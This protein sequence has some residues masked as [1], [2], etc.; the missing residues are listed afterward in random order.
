MRRFAQYGGVRVNLL[1]TPEFVLDIRNSAK[2]LTTQIHIGREFNEE[3]L[4][5]RL[6]PDVPQWFG[7]TI[8]FWD[9]DALITWTSNVQ[10]W[11]SHGG[12]EFSNQ[13]QSIEIYTPRTGAEGEYIGLKHEAILYDDKAF[14]QP[15]RIVH[16]L[17]KR[18]ELSQGDPFEI[19]EC[20]PQTFP[21]E[22]QATPMSP[23]Q[24]FEYIVPDIY[25]RPWAKIWE[26]Y[27]EQGMEKPKEKK[28]FGF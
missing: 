8:G 3:G 6:G 9:G 14:A 19:M 20:V 5:P 16:F 21:L 27:H 24:T 23:G 26:R 13:L 10:S 17:D 12:F 15:L 4:V 11:I 22:G 18:H 25:G 7:D 1:V 2:T 28:L